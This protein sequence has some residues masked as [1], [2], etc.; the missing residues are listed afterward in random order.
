MGVWW[1]LLRFRVWH[2]RTDGHPNRWHI[3]TDGQMVSSS[4]LKMISRQND[5]PT[6]GHLPI[7]RHCCGIEAHAQRL[8]LSP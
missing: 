3:R 7:A 2:I 1:A 6:N 5:L 4:L 8:D